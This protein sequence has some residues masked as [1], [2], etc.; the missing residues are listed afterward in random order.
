MI[1]IL[2]FHACSIF[3]KGTCNFMFF[4][5]LI[6]SNSQFNLTFFWVNSK[7]I[8]TQLLF[9]VFSTLHL[10]LVALLVFSF[11]KIPFLNF[12]FH[13][14]FF[15]CTPRPRWFW[16]SM[17]KC[18]VTCWKKFWGS[19]GVILVEPCGFFLLNAN[20][21]MYAVKIFSPKFANINHTFIFQD[22]KN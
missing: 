10:Q 5:I 2:S 11:L 15:P 19:S 16:R 22:F 18:S 17:M 4:L 1:F 8:W 3:K 21:Y 9:L 12:F 20:F 7:L 6:F 13:N 14:L